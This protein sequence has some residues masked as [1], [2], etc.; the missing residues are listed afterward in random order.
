M[1]ADRV[2]LLALLYIF[3]TVL[4]ILGPWHFQMCFWITKS[5]SI[6]IPARIFDWGFVKATNPFG[7]N[8]HPHT[9]GS[10]SNRSHCRLCFLQVPQ[11]MVTWEPNFMLLFFILGSSDQVVS[12]EFKPQISWRQICDYEYPG[13]YLFIVH[14]MSILR[15]LSIILSRWRICF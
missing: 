14:L 15:F 13:K 3:K 7:E 10:S 11:G 2:S 1:I 4:V 12:Y 8:R 6:K 9:V 5:I